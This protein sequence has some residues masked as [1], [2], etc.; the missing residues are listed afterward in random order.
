MSFKIGFRY[1]LLIVMLLL[2]VVRFIKG[3]EY[4]IGPI[5]LTLAL[6]SLNGNDDGR[7]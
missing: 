5:F 6:I 1:F 7:R 4:V 3:D 2:F